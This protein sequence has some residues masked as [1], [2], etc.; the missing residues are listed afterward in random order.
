MV[1]VYNKE[2]GALIWNGADDQVPHSLQAGDPISFVEDAY[3]VEEIEGSG[4]DRT[5]YVRHHKL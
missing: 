2:T 1:N 4:G 3:V 5:I